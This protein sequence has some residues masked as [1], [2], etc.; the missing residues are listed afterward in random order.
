MMKQM[1]K[2]LLT[3]AVMFGAS[4]ALYGGKEG[5]AATINLSS[6]GQ[7]TCYD[8]AG[9]TIDCTGTGQDGDKKMGVTLNETTRFANNGDGTVTDNLTGLIWLQDANCTDA[10]GGITRHGPDTWPDALTWSN[11]L[12]SGLCGLTDSSTVG[13]WRV[14]S[15]NELQSLA[16]SGV[17]NIGDWLNTKGFKNVDPSANGYWTSTSFA[18]DG[19]YAWIINMQHIDTYYNF[20]TAGNYVWPVRDAQ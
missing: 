8:F 13:M 16:N 12:T 7:I 15:R 17:L 2:I 20:K 1:L 11:N 19:N 9:K 5:H 4:L 10:A 18:G 6:S 3:L 14:P